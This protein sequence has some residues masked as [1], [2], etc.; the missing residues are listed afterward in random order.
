MLE[1]VTLQIIFAQMGQNAVANILLFYTAVRRIDN[2]PYRSTA[3]TACQRLQ[4]SMSVLKT[5]LSRWA[6]VIAA[7]HGA[8]IPNEAFQV[9]VAVFCVPFQQTPPLKKSGNTMTDCV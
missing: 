8:G 1:P 3:V 5:R 7:R 9:Q 2:D 4:A 6:H